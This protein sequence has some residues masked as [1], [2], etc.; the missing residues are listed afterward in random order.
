MKYIDSFRDKSLVFALADKIK[1]TVC[2]EKVYKIMEICGTH[3]MTIA[4]FGIK[5]LL[6][7]NIKLV[8]GPGC[9]ICVI[10]QGEIDAI[11]KVAKNPDVIL[12]TYGDLLKTP[13]SNNEN[14]LQ[15]RAKG[16]DIRVIFSPL[17]VIDI[18]KNTTKK[19]IFISIGFE[20][21]VPATAAMILEAKRQ[22]I[23]NIAIFPYNKTMPAIMK[24]LLSQSFLDIDGFLC[25]GNVSVITGL[26]MYRVISDHKKAAVIAGFEAVDILAAIYRIICQVNE[27]VF[28]VENIYK[29]A[30][31]QDGNIKAKKLIDLVFEPSSSLWRGVGFIENS[32]LALKMTFK[33]YNILQSFDIKIESVFD[34]QGCLCG[35]VLLGS[36]E[37]EDCPLFGRD[38]SPEL[39]VGPCMVYSEGA[40]A[41]RYRYGN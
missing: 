20:T 12:A 23:T 32:G 4:R 41:A 13:G 35:S 9:P 29:R 3:T 6:P 15:A 2:K 25:P 5:K 27:Q 7:E 17:D 31:S 18:A 19:V 40:C 38:C 24:F 16:S 11:F 22:N 10:S 36:L 14:L 39:P 37:P 21:T 34:K 30:V 28:C 33:E 8:S 1:D 26:D